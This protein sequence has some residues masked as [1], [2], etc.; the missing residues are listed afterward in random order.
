M[1]C[2]HPR[3]MVPTGKFY[4]KSGK[5]VYE[6]IK[7]PEDKT[8]LNC[9][10][11]GVIQV[12][13]G[14]CLGCRL[15]YSRQWADRMMLELQTSKK[16]IFVTLTYDNEHIPMR[17]DDDDQFIG[18]TL[19]K[20]DCQLF[21]KN[22]RRDYDG[23]DGHPYAKIRFYLSS[24]YGP[25]FGRPHYH[26]ILFGLGL[27]DFPLAE[28]K[29][30]NELGQD[31]FDVPELRKAWPNGFV[32]VSDVSWATCAYVARYTMKKVFEE[33][34]SLSG[35]E[36]G[37]EREFSLMSR[38]PGIGAEYLA[39]HDDALDYHTIS[40]SSGKG[41]HKMYIPNYYL[42]KVKESHLLPN[43]PKFDKMF[44][45]RKRFASDAALSKMSRTSLGYIDQLELEE[46]KRL[47]ST[48]VS[49]SRKLD[50]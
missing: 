15:D 45:D 42:R 30:K 36:C 29:G 41:A 33:Q 44:E 31:F 21:M 2:Y 49:L 7:E 34:S 5:P 8:F 4:S 48:Q 25:T 47:R 23:R 12:P 26:C 28:F 18:Y 3:L 6:F 43:N 9:Y 46:E 22:I 50:N 20:E 17:F 14:K 13:C 27:D 24:E 38:R 10:E 35:F 19:C 11:D 39:E 1:S 16:A 37:V 40:V 32:T